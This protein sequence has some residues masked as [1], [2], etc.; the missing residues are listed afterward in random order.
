PVNHGRALDVLQVMKSLWSRG[1]GTAQFSSSCCFRAA[2]DLTSSQTNYHLKVPAGGMTRGNA[3]QSYCRKK[4]LWELSLNW[5]REWDFYRPTPA[6][7][8]M[9]K[10]SSQ[11]ISSSQVRSYLQLPI[12]SL[13]F[14]F[15]PAFLGHVSLE[16]VT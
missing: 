2:C 11:V 15:L 14:T 6:S 1:L 12:F 16:C 5:R 10:N 9:T 8:M 13:F 3:T 7:P 4:T